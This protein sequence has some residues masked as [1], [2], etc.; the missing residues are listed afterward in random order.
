MSAQV[1]TMADKLVADRLGAPSV[2]AFA[3]T[4]AAPIMVVGAII[5]TALA[6]TGVVGVGVALLIV[7]AILAVWAV[8]YVTMARHVSN[9]GS[10]YTYVAHGFGPIPAVGALLVQLL[11]YSMMQVSLYGVWGVQADAILG[12]LI[13]VRAPWWVWALGALALVTILGARNVGVVSRIL[14]VTVLAELVVVTIVS[15][16]NLAHPASGHVTLDALDPRTLTPS[17]LGVMLAIAATAFVGVEEAPVYSEESKRLRITILVGTFA[18]LGLMVVP[19][20][21]GAWSMTVAA[22]SDRI[23]DVATELGPDT[24]VLPASRHWGGQTLVD[25]FHLLLLTSIGAAMVAYHNAVSRCAFAAGRERVL[26]AALGRT[27]PT[28]GAPIVASLAQNC[29]GLVTIVVFAAG[30]WDPMTAM[31]YILGT[32][33]AVGVFT[34]MTAASASV[35][36]YFA[37]DRREEGVWATAILPTLATLALTGC[38]CLI[39]DNYPSLV[40]VAPDSPARWLP[41]G[42]LGVFVLGVLHGLWLRAKRPDVLRL[43]GYGANAVLMDNHLTPSPALQ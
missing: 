8:G 42:V 9:A 20:V 13:G 1:S 7:A 10:L 21:L 6:V 35:V 24:L 39:L 34:L 15:M 25:I 2:M 14:A 5:P 28:T 30:G 17:A 43:V 4:A 18:A 3:L 29:C 26:P 22:G 33:G 27:S 16:I 12:G 36:A 37:R 11:V 19:Y 38:L 41:L 23:V 40:G 31:F 32:T